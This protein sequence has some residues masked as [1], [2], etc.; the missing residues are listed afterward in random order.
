MSTRCRIQF[1]AVGA[2]VA[3]AC[4]PC[5]PAGAAGQPLPTSH[6]GRVGVVVPG[7]SE[8]LL[9]RRAGPGSTRVV[10]VR[11]TGG[12]VLRSRTI[13]GRWAVPAVTLDGGTT[14][15]SGDG[16]T[17][18]LGRPVSSYPPRS[19]ALA[20]VG[21]AD[22]SVRR[23]ISLPGFF[24]VDAISPHGRWAY[25]IQYAGQNPYDYRVRAID[26]ATGALA[27]RDVVD[28]REP[29]EQ[30]RG[31]AMTRT[32]SR[33]GRWVYT[34]YGGGSET[35]IHALD[36]VGRTAA[37]I[38]L[39][40]LPPN[41]DLS[42]VALSVDGDGRHLTVRSHGDVEATVDTHTFA[43]SEGAEPPA[44]TTGKPAADAARDG[45]GPPWFVIALGAVGLAAAALVAW[46]VQRSRSATARVSST[47]ER[48]PSLP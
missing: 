45:G 11:R 17:L 30:M 4:V 24:T 8:R 20:V 44:A 25:L 43:V 40:M 2:V 38:D 36:T 19:T 39:E 27:A 14:G 29:E 5:V 32:A 12:G 21:T 35:F 48:T 16:S 28:P 33:D 10:A 22:L 42:R 41:G 37:C 34:L 18:L 1:V 3:A 46:R 23:T 13:A 15:L 31:L 7:G 47:R 26:L 9:T 6:S